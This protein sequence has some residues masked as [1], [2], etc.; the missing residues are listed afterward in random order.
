M[1]D[2]TRGLRPFIVLLTMAAWFAVSNHCALGA[3]ESS[4]IS[5]AAADTCCH[6]NV[7]SP[8]KAPVKDDKAP[9][10]KTLR[11]LTIKPAANLNG[12]F[13]GA[14]KPFA[15]P[16]ASRIPVP[17]RITLQLRPLETGPPGRTTFAELV[18]QRSILSHAPPLLA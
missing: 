14:Y 18:L 9:C 1:K 13:A 12:G 7:G 4:K 2:K 10:C 6:G 8:A 15:Y 17:V 11:A 5:P 3:L 16:S